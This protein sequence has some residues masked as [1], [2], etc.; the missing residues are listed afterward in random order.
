MSNDRDKIAQ[1]AYQIYEQRGKGN[2][3][4]FNDWLQAE[5]ELSGQEN[6]KKQP[7]KKKMFPY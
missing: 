3:S 5:K 4:D 7:I 2:G 6:S 1:R